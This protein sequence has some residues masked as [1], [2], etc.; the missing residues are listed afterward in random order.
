MAALT[1]TWVDGARMTS[2]T[3]ASTATG[4]VP[5]C[6]QPRN[7]GLT[8]A[9]ASRTCSSNVM[10]PTVPGNSS[11]MR[12]GRVVSG[13]E[14]DIRRTATMLEVHRSMGLSDL[15]YRIYEKRIQ[16]HLDRGR[17][18]QHVAVL[19]DGN[20]RW[21]R[22]LSAPTSSGHQAGAERAHEFLGWC[23]EAGVRVVTLWMLSTD[24][25]NRPEDE[26]VP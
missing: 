3:P 8:A 21:A 20:R 7:R 9:T 5:A 11:H 4:K 24:N 13:R 17:L 10:N 16:R 23:D 12:R 15:V 2:R 18:P 1:R 25:L 26:L 6:S 19:M 22:A 14:R